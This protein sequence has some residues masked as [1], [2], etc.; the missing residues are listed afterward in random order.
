MRLSAWFALL[1]ITVVRAVPP[2]AGVTVM[3]KSLRGNG[4][5]DFSWVLPAK[6]RRQPRDAKIQ[7]YAVEYCLVGAPWLRLPAAGTPWLR[8]AASLGRAHCRIEK[9]ASGTYEYR[10]RHANRIGD[11]LLATGTFTIP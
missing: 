10:V 2:P 1:V 6:P 11:S 9:L 7:A 3:T 8:V 4:R 5:A